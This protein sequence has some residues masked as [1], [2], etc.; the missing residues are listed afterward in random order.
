MKVRIVQLLC[1]ER[2]CVLA[3]AYQ[4]P[5]GEADPIKSALLRETFDGLLEKKALNP[6]CGICRSTRLT[7]EDSETVFKTMEEAGPFLQ[8]S[9]RKQEATAA[10]L[11]STRQ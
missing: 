2:H 6:W 1:P 5:T 10:Y 8:E 4:S 9:V 7:C 3:V 11:R